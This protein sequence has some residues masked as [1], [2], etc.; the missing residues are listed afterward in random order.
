MRYGKM[1]PSLGR[2]HVVDQILRSSYLNVS[3]QK[4]LLN[5]VSLPMQSSYFAVRGLWSV[6]PT[7]TMQMFIRG[8]P[9]EA[10][11]DCHRNP[12]IENLGSDSLVHN[13]GATLGAGLENIEADRWKTWMLAIQ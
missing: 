11:R 9:P 3:W 10:T 6:L 13:D 12:G 2:A 7:S 4:K 5:P 1:I 8:S